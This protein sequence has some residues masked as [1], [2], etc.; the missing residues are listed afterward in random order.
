MIVQ[1]RFLVIQADTGGDG[2][3]FDKKVIV[4]RLVESRE[5]VG[6]RVEVSGEINL[7]QFVPLDSKLRCFWVIRQ[8]VVECF[9]QN[10]RQPVFLEDHRA[11]RVQAVIKTVGAEAPLV[12]AFCIGFDCQ[13]FAPGILFL[14]LVKGENRLFRIVLVHLHVV[15]QILVGR[16]GREDKTVC[17]P[18]Q[19]QAVVQRT[20]PVGTR[21]VDADRL[22]SPGLRV[23]LPVGEGFLRC[24]VIVECILRLQMVR[25]IPL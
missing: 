18:F 24:I 7:V 5:A 8:Y 19:I 20:A 17:F 25:N 11:V 12:I 3:P 10:A 23:V 2:K 13:F 4:G 1:V 6:W 15:F 22:H 14:L 16:G 21:I 9:L